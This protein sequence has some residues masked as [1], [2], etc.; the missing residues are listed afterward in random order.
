MMA[1]A[2]QAAAP[3]PRA[4]RGLATSDSAPMTG[5]PI[6]VLPTR[7]IDH[8]AVTRPRYSGSEASWMVALPV[9]RKM[10]LATLASTHAAIAVASVGATASRPTAIA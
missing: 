8:K 3:R 9:V 10:T 1:A 6:G 4:Y 7:A 5:E 2:R